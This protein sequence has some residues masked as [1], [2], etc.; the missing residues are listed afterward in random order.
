MQHEDSSNTQSMPFLKVL[1]LADAEQD[2]EEGYDPYN[3]A[4]NLVIPEKE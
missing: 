1:T 2:R 4:T 3:T